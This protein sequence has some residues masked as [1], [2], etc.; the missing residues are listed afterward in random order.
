[1]NSADSLVVAR[2]LSGFV[3]PETPERAEIVVL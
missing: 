1:V 3:L 2:N